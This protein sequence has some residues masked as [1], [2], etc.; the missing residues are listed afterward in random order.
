[1]GVVAEVGRYDVKSSLVVAPFETFVAHGY[2]FAFVVG[3]S[4]RLGKP[5][6]PGGPYQVVFAVEHAVDVGLY[7]F[8]VDD[9]EAARQSR[10]SFL[11]RQNRSV[12]LSRCCVLRAAGS[13]VALFVWYRRG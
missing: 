8:I 7:A 5:F 12:S 2:E 1:M 3:G 11:C 6:Y 9:R 10:C 13:A 4:R